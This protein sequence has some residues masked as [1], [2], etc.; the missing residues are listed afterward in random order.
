MRLKKDVHTLT[1]S[2]SSESDSRWSNVVDT[3]SHPRSS[4]LLLDSY[5]NVWMRLILD[6]GISH[7]SFHLLLLLLCFL[8][9]GFRWRVCAFFFEYSYCSFWDDDGEI[10][11]FD[12]VSFF[13]SFCLLL[14]WLL[15]TNP[16]LTIK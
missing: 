14:G 16:H 10:N 3:L 8:C 13:S 5:K 9:G 1:S 6:I 2:C 7:Y 11:V 4:Q 15:H 12:D